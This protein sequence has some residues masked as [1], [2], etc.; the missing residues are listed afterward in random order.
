MMRSVRHLSAACLGLVLAACSSAPIHFHT[1]VPPAPETAGTGGAA[2]PYR[3]AVAPVTI[4]AGVDQPALVVRQGQGSMALLEN[5]QWI[6]PLGDE[7]RT[8]VSGELT[9]R[10]GTRDVYG[11]TGSRD[12]PVYR[13]KIDIARFESVP[14]QYA[15][16][17]AAWSINVVG[18]FGGD[19][20]GRVMQCGNTIREP[21]GPGY[22]ALVVGHQQALKTLADTIA[23]AIRAMR[24]GTDTPCPSAVANAREG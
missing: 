21:V 14:S 19:G 18:K 6:A 11:L 17:S 9:R 4:P 12:K 22:D 15:L 24:Q 2:A 8:V 5:Q 3:I 13:V 16:L 20:E 23:A 10:L 7:I 1:L